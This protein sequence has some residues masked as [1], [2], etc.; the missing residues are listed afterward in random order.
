MNNEQLKMRP[1]SNTK[2]KM[3]ASLIVILL[4]LALARSAPPTLKFVVG[5]ERQ[6]S[7]AGQ[8]SSYG[9]TLANVES[10][11]SAGSLTG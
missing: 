10:K 4:C 5:T 3:K 9:K 11:D 7:V 2:S 6:Y 8:V 1:R